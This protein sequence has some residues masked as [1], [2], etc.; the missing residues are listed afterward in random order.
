ME[1]SRW[2]LNKERGEHLLLVGFFFVIL[3]CVLGDLKGDVFGYIGLV[4]GT[5]GL[6]VL[7]G[8]LRSGKLIPLP[9]WALRLFLSTNVFLS[10]LLIIMPIGRIFWQW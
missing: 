6:W 7:F 9:K 5:I 4:V 3:G 8:C 1:N 2:K 10:V